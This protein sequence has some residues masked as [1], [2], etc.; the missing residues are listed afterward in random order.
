MM[1]EAYISFTRDSSEKMSSFVEM[2]LVEKVTNNSN[3]VYN[4]KKRLFK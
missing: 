4:N 2:F 3:F 1:I